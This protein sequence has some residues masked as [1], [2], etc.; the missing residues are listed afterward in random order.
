MQISVM[1][2]GQAGLTWARWKQLVKVVED[3]GFYGLYRSDHFVHPSPPNDNSL[4]M[5][6]SLTYLADHTKR[7]Q[8]G[9]LV[10]PVSF[11]DPVML[12]RQAMALDDLSGGRMILGLG[13]GWMEREHQMFGYPLGD[14]KTRMARLEEGLEVVSGLVR[15]KSPFSL[16]GH[17]YTLDNAELLP[18]PTRMGGPPIL[19]GGNGQN[20]TLQMAARFADIWNGV[21]VNPARFRELSGVLDGHLKAIGRVPA[22]VK[23]TAATFLVFGSDRHALEEAAKPFSSWRPELEGRTAD[24][25]LAFMRDERHAV[26]GLADQVGEQLRAYEAAGVE[27]IMLQYFDSGDIEGIKA[28]AA[29]VL[30]DFN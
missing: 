8:F 26:V 15:G 22:A 17:Y 11:R 4:E 18:A 28:L 7:V 27:E 5:I 23:R 25:V 1:V 19:I 20:R 10:A 21:Q 3:L 13:A 30:P 16:K 6:V 9:P 2:E 12:A 24:E 14:K 29:Q